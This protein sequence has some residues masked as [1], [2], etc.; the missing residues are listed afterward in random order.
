MKEKTLS[1]WRS[2]VESLDQEILQLLAQRFLCSR[3]IGKIK[4]TAGLPVHDPE[5]EDRLILKYQKHSAGHLSFT[6]IKDLFEL[7]FAE[8]RRYQ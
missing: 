4:Q 1:E 7:I 3:A 8:S 2:Q 6:F 5:R